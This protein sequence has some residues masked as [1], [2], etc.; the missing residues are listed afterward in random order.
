[1]L[2]Q[3]AAFFRDRKDSAEAAHALLE[4]ARVQR[5]RPGASAAVI[6]SLRSALEQADYSRRNVLVS[7]IKRELAEVNQEEL[8]RR[9]YRRAHRCRYSRGYWL[10]RRNPGVKRQPF[11]SSTCATSPTFR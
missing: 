1:M 11:F 7:E 6:E 8:F 5:R 4:L 10:S 9:A 2:R 3:V